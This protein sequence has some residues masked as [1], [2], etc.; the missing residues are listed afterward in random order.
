MAAATYFHPELAVQPPP[1]PHNPALSASPTPF[2]AAYPAPSPLPTPPPTSLSQSFATDH[3]TS[4]MPKVGQTRCYWALLSADLQFIY[5]DPVL[6]AHLEDQAP[7]LVG[8]S[9]LTLVHPDERQTAQH[10]LGNVLNSKTLHG[11]VTRVRFS[12]LSKVRRDLGYKGP[13]DSWSE[14][15]KVALDD[16]YMAVEI[17]INWVADGLVLC[18]IHATVDLS[19]GD[20]DEQRKTGWTNWCGTPFVHQDQVDLLFSRLLMCIPQTGSWH[21]VFQILTNDSDK[22]LLLSWPPEPAQL[23]EG[24]AQD[25]AKLV[26]TV[27]MGTA[28]SGVKDAK[29]SC[30]RRFKALQDIPILGGE[31]ESIFI[32]HGSIIFACH[33]VT[34]SSRG[35]ANSSAGMHQLAFA[36]SGYNSNAG[37]AYYDPNPYTLPPI[38][39]QEPY[40]YM[41]QH[42]GPMYSPQKWSPSV[43]SS[44][45]NLRSNTYA[46]SLNSQDQSW[47]SSGPHTTAVHIPTANGNRGGSPP[48]PYSPTTTASSTSPTS[49]LV[50]PPRRRVSP[51][52]R[53]GRQAR[54]HGS[55]PAGITKCMGCETTSSPEWRKGPSGKKELCNACGLRFARQRAKKEGHPQN[56]RRPRKTSGVTKREPSTPHVPTSPIYGVRKL[57]AP[58]GKGYSPEKYYALDHKPYAIDTKPFGSDASF[59]T[60]TNGGYSQV[61]SMTPSPSPPG[62][63]TNMNFMHYTDSR[64]P[65]ASSTSFY[66]TSGH[67]SSNISHSASHPPPPL[68]SGQQ[69]STQLPPISSYVDRLMP[70]SSP[71]NL[72]PFSATM[73]PSS[74]ER[75]RERDREYRDLA[76]LSAEPRMK[77]TLMSQ[78]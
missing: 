5:L 60:S 18:F 36:A 1:H 50:P 10:D 31:V 4:A 49:D 2:L 40:S 28:L 17:V 67:P 52:N 47:E 65:Y 16:E 76:P 7:Y 53:E 73:A 25:F 55:R 70:S 34:P 13:I 58:D 42:Q 57:Y 68:S 32:P 6:A 44:M 20:N 24:G 23:S 35:P 59:T 54:N 27:N 63:G 51:A 3:P 72:S 30:T 66:P 33:K 56:Q 41:P 22:R 19:P 69:P 38:S 8:K 74:Y 46:Q 62:T 37:S 26:D 15:D 75:D 9:L 21:R 43:P 64:A 48:Y 77:R 71:V 39:T 11:T 29:T 12:R 61:Q 45:A 14:A 78:Q